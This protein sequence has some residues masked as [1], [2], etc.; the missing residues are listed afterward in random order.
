MKKLVLAATLLAIGCGNGVTGE[1][2]VA[3]CLTLNA[4]GM[5]KVGAS[6]CTQFIEAV[7]EPAVEGTI[8]ISAAQVNCVASAGSNCD[9]ARACL[10]G[11]QKPAMCSGSSSMCS[12]NTW[13]TCDGL[14]GSGGTNGTRIFDCGL[15]GSGATCVVGASILGTAR[16]DCGYGSC[17]PASTDAVKCLDTNTVQTC[18]RGIVGKTDCSRNGETCIPGGLLPA[19]CAGAGA[20]CAVKT[21]GDS[22]IRC[23]GNTLVSCSGQ[24]EAKVDCG[25]DNLKCLPTFAGSN[26]SA[27][28]AFGCYLGNE[29]DPNAYSAQCNGLQLTFCNKGKIQTA[30]CGQLGFSGCDPSGGGS[31]TKS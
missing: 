6:A 12:G 3:A 27:N 25:R 31:C 19:H 18:D 5:V 1:T 7:N 4:C 14:T 2:G 15:V 26:G 28:P 16:I 22:T 21:N 20:G 11:G 9:A 30:Q 24:H 23:D 29:C 17:D 8:H 10:N 13:S